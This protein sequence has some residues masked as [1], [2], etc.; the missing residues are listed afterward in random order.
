MTEIRKKGSGGVI[1]KTLFVMIFITL[2][3]V[4]TVPVGL[5]IYSVKSDIGIN[6][7]SHTGFHSYMQCLREQAYKVK[8]ENKTKSTST[9]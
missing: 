8:I 3:L 9:Q 4:S 2:Y 5:F 1:R 7:F 6:V